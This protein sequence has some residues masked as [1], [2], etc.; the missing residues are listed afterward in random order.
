MHGNGNDFII[1]ENLTKVNA[2]SKSQIIK[3]GD[4]NKGIG[5]DQLITINPPK[6]P[7]HDFYVN[8]FN[9][10]GSQAD[11]CMNGVR[12]VGAFLWDARLAPKKSLLLGTKSKPILIKPTNTKK[13]KVVFD[14]PIQE[15]IPKGETVFLKNYGLNKYNSYEELINSHLNN[16]ITIDQFSEKILQLDIDSD[17]FKISSKSLGKYSGSKT[18]D[19]V[20]HC[21]PNSFIPISSVFLHKLSSLDIIIDDSLLVISS[22]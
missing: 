2:L 19:P 18:P 14:C 11:M 21:N 10:D 4:R 17:I 8:F 20:I 9:S 15:I 1:I 16:K 22:A 6:K 12:S 3:I 7:D 5:F 13:V